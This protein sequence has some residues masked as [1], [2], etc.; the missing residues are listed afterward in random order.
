[1][2][3]PSCAL[4]A[5]TLGKPPAGADFTWNIASLI[6]QDAKLVDVDVGE[7]AD[8]LSQELEDLL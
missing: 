3:V 7:E 4:T 1:M 6:A 5:R 8:R 2:A